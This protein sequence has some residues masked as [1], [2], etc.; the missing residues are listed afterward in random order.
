[1]ILLDSAKIQESDAEYA[2]R[3]GFS[4]HRPALPLYETRDVTRALKLFGNEPRGKWF[5]VAGP[6]ACHYHDAGHLLGSTSVEM[7][8]RTGSRPLRI[9]FSGDVGHYDAPLYNDPAAPSAC[10]FLVCESMY[11]DR[12]HRQND[13]L[14]QLEEV[15]PRPLAAAA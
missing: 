11:G 6:I 15:V 5:V 4:K 3:K 7:E 1:M 9:V 14:D 2:N 8:I 12:D 13:L 10:D